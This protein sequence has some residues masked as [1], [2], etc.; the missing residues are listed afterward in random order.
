MAAAH[1]TRMSLNS[2]LQVDAGPPPKRAQAK[3]HRQDTPRVSQ[4]FAES[5]RT[6]LAEFM[7]SPCAGFATR[8]TATA[9]SSRTSA[10]F[11]SED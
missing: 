8:R 3:T 2:F 10:A 5:A 7:N 11:T 9:A 1:A 4:L 6:K